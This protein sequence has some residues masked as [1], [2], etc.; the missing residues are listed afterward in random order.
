MRRERL[1]IIMP[2]LKQ[3]LLGTGVVENVALSDHTTLY[4]G[5]N[6]GRF[7]WKGKSPGC[8]NTC[9]YKIC[10]ARIYTDIRYE[11]FVGQRLPANGFLYEVKSQM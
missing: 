7:M 4:G 6:T 2:P 3:D 5:N 1:Q 11:S 8:T 10:Y 9:F